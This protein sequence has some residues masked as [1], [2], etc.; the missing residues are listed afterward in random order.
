MFNSSIFLGGLAKVATVSA[1]FVTTSAAAETTLRLS[2]YASTRSTTHEAA[3]YFASEIASRTNGEIKIT[4][5]PAHEL[6]DDPSQVRGVRVGTIDMAV[7]GNTFFSGI[8]PEVNALD[9]PYLFAS[10]EHAYTVLDGEIGEDI[11]QLFSGKGFEVL[12]NWEIGFRNI[13]NN[14][15]PV[16]KPADLV[17]LKLRTNPNP[18]HVLAFETWGAQPTPM[19]FNEV[20]LALETSAVDGQENP[21]GLIHAMRFNEVQEHLSMTR[22]AYTAAFLVMNGPKYKGLDEGIRQI[23]TEV[24]QLAGQMERDL[25]AERESV[26]LAEMQAAG[27]KV[28]M[29]PDRDAFYEMAADVIRSDYVEKYGKSLLDRIDAA[30]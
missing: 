27:L 21:V 4:V 9:L 22:H 11:H 3:E 23:L 30:R 17:G 25:N 15:R 28:V 26:S 1:L 19:P 7:V 5:H 13:T 8:I 14:V 12:G 29:E 16:T 24:G 2:H 6:G 20:Y 10:P 18:A